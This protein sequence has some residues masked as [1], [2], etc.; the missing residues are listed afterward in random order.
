LRLTVLA[1]AI[2]FAALVFLSIG[3]RVP[4]MS[5]EVGYLAIARYMAT[6]QKLFV[7]F[8]PFYSAGQSVLL[9][10]L[11]KLGLH[12]QQVYQAGIWISILATAL[13][14]VV[15]VAAAKEMQFPMDRKLVAASVIAAIMP[16]YF[17]HVFLLW[18]EATL[19]LA[20][21]VSFYLLAVAWNRKSNVVWLA[22]AAVIVAMYALHSRS[23][24]L[25]PLAAL[26]IW[27]GWRYQKMSIWAAGASV[28]VIGAGFVLAGKM[29]HYFEVQ[30]WGASRGDISRAGEMAA[31]LATP[32]GNHR[33]VAEAMGQAWVILATS[34]CLF[35]VGFFSLWR[36]GIERLERMVPLMFAALACLAVFIPS[37]AVMI[38]FNRVDQVIY[39]RYTGVV[40]TI[41]VWLGVIY[42]AR[43]VDKHRAVKFLGI[44]VLAMLGA[45]LLW[46][47]RQGAPTLMITPNISGLLWVNYFTNA[48]SAS[49]KTMLLY[50]TIGGGLV[51][52][53][54]TALPRRAVLPV[55]AVVTVGADAMIYHAVYGAHIGRGYYIGEASRVYGKAKPPIF[56][57]ASLGYNGNTLMDQYVLGAMLPSDIG[58]VDLQPGQA[59]VVPGTF[60]KAG[61]CSLGTFPD[62]SKLLTKADSCLP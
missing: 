1:S 21:I 42:L 6:G 55:L 56:W 11:F 27:I 17:Y 61:Y 52:L 25:I 9:A 57:D 19:R 35:A 33:M 46:V 7:Q 43:D 13:V 37:V 50:G 58:K 10:P 12:S 15:L 62:G 29:N 28:A 20:F 40:T 59:T 38:Q 22:F 2:L 36:F 34:F 48:M 3:I 30:L 53:L 5:D 16:A 54:L 51:A 47:F 23:I 8:M 4:I 32:E 45:A 24:L 60:E 26:M 44:A 39:E 49:L 14:P 31:A 41:P 18:P